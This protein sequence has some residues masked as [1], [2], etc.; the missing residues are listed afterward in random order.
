MSLADEIRRTGEQARRKLEKK[1]PSWAGAGI[2]IPASINL[3]QCSS[4]LTARYKAGL[5]AP[6]SRVADLT[7]GLGA[8]SWAFSLNAEALWYNEADAALAD[9][10]K[11]NFALLG[12]RNAFFNSFLIEAGGPGWAEALRGFRPD[13]IYL[14]PA[15]RNAAGRKVFL[16]ED[17]SPDV[18]TLLPALLETAPQVIIKVSPM[19]DITMLCRRLGGYLESVHVVGAGGEC[20]ELLCICRKSAAFTGVVLSEDG[21]PYSGSAARKVPPETSASLHPSRCASLAGPSHSRGHGRPRFPETPSDSAAPEY[22]LL[23]VPS[24]AMVKSGLGPGMGLME[25][26]RELA[27]FGKYWQIVENLPFASSEIKRLG[28]RWPQAEVTA[29]GV[30]VSSEEL[31]KKTGT[32][33]GGP[34]HIFAC[35]LRGERRLLVCKQMPGPE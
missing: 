24:A 32:K 28:R 6:G 16:L 12:V 34:V 4:E 2:S 23:F 21:R 26:D 31:R 1:L 30:P 10:V 22:G 5:V 7:G 15:R 25:Y 14:D 18:T 20:K 33:P 13:V 9:A 3:E 17:C 35:Q 8:D 19:A 29:R 27:H 11:A